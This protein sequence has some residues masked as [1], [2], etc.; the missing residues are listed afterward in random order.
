MTWRSRFCTKRSSTRRGSLS[1]SAKGRRATSAAVSR[2]SRRTAR[3]SWWCRGRKASDEQL[4]A[5]D[6]SFWRVNEWLEERN[7]VVTFKRMQIPPL[8]HV[9][10]RKPQVSSRIGG[11]NGPELQTRTN[12]R[13]QLGGGWAGGRRPAG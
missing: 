4:V 2:A 12:G 7:L 8:L 11:A 10:R 3:S 6:P 13:R 9:W 1:I 5:S